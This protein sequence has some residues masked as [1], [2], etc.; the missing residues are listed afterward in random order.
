MDDFV[1]AARRNIDILRQCVLAESHWFQEFFQQDFP[2]VILTRSSKIEPVMGQGN[3]PNLKHTSVCAGQSRSSVQSGSNISEAGHG[4]Y[5]AM[6]GELVVL[7]EPPAF[8]RG[9]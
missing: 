6:V 3:P 2:G 8:M 1:D 4:A 9:E 5:S 7:P